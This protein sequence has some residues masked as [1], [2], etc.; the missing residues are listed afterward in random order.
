MSTKVWV[1]QYE[2]GK[3]GRVVTDASGAMTRAKA[4]QGAKV[5]EKN[6]WRGWVAHHQTQERIFETEQEIAHQREKA[7]AE[8]SAG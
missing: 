7:Q 5:I 8:Q 4:L 6:G 1:V 3:T 2:V